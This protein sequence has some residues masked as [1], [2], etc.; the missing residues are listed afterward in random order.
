[1]ARHFVGCRTASTLAKKLKHSIHIH[2]YTGL[3][4]SYMSGNCD[5]TMYTLQ[6]LSIH[7]LPSN[8]TGF[9]NTVQH[10]LKLLQQVAGR[11]CS[12]LLSRSGRPAEVKSFLASSGS[13][14]CTATRPRRASGSGTAANCLRPMWTCITFRVDLF[15]VR[16]V[17]LV[18]PHYCGLHISNHPFPI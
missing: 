11:A 5:R 15:A 12:S 9:Q 1:M 2:I 7:S 4:A 18:L 10:R 3:T 13:P 17:G 8:T 14:S 16:M 6:N